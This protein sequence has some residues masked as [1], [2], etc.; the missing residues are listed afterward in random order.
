MTEEIKPNETLD[1]LGL[2]CP[3]PIMKT[4]EKIKQM[5]E[6][7]VLEVVADDVGILNDMPAWCKT[8]GNEFLGSKTEE[9]SYKVYVRKKS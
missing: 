1:C 6:G 2:Y 7:E 3:V 5:K 8:T 4:Y 9:N